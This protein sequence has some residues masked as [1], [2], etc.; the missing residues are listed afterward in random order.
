MPSID[1]YIPL[2]KV[3]DKKEREQ[4]VA[5]YKAEYKWKEAVKTNKELNSGINFDKFISSQPDV[6]SKDDRP[7]INAYFKEKDD[8]IWVC[9][10]DFGE[11]I[12]LQDGITITSLEGASPPGLL[13][14]PMQ[15]E[16]KWGFP[17]WAQVGF[18]GGT[19]YCDE[20]SQD[21]QDKTVMP[22]AYL[23][24]ISPIAKILKNLEYS[25]NVYENFPLN[26]QAW[27]LGWVWEELSDL[28]KIYRWF[29]KIDFV[30]PEAIACLD[31]DEI[32][33]NNWTF[34]E[35]RKNDDPNSAMSSVRKVEEDIQKLKT[36]K[37]PLSKFNEKYT[38]I[39]RKN[40]KDTKGY[41]PV[42]KRNPFD[43]DEW[44]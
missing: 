8:R 41:I 35:A 1:I 10:Y 7:T 11:P 22:Y 29:K 40:K 38:D 14:I 37:L 23:I 44:E 39:L 2:N 36:G 9:P 12:G 42:I 24:W 21:P 16:F 34:E 28:R 20:K 31:W 25:I 32:A 5:L 33:W 4:L 26:G 13:R 27:Q 30:C 17:W 18:A 43:D 15:Y 19:K 3:P 6:P